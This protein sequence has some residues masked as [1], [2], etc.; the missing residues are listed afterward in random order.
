MAS[1]RDGIDR[2]VA[3]VSV[4]LENGYV[5]SLGCY[6]LNTL[7]MSEEKKQHNRNVCH[8]YS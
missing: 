5:K 6:S 2:I 8:Q 3:H 1:S 7:T 4:V